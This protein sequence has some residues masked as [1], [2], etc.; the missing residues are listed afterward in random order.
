[1][2]AA[3]LV[4]R[5]ASDAR[6]IAVAR[7]TK[8]G[9]GPSSPASGLDH[10]AASRSASRSSSTHR[11]AMIEDQL[12]LGVV[13]RPD[14]VVCALA[15]AVARRPGHGAVTAEVAGPQTDAE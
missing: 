15:N 11:E 10:L 4:L 9:G 8:S 3:R 14:G 5:A 13:G 12:A 6:T 1:M 7:T 2:L